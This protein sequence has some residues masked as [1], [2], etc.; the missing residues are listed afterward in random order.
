MTYK[1]SIPEIINEANNKNWIHVFFIVN[2]ITV[3]V[4][5]MIIEKYNINK[6]NIKIFSFRNTDTSLID[7]SVKRIKTGNYDRYLEKFFWYSPTSRFITKEV[8][9]RNTNFILYTSWLYLQA[10]NLLKSKYSRG[11]IYIEEGQHSYMNIKE[12]DLKKVNLLDKLKRNWKNRYS[13][14]DE[15]GFYYRSDSSCVIGISND[16]F[17]AI[18]SDKRVILSNIDLLKKYY[19]PKLKNIKTIGLTC[20]SRRLEKNEWAKMLISV[21]K[22]MK[23]GGVIKLH[24]SFTVS[25]QIKNEI[26][27]LIHSYNDKKIKI[28]PNDVILELE[29]LYEKKSIIGYQTSLSKYCLIFGS[30]F[31]Q[32]D[33]RAIKLKK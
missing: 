4:S 5:R 10:E 26:I 33:F 19:K 3:I 25:D 8:E 29:M 22:R 28:C 1:E 18:K 32:I 31:E 9:K 13:E 12:F 6:K 11:H 16:I 15:V 2:P 14:E 27:D 30:N 7:F 17:P 20:S 21:I 23:N 24:P